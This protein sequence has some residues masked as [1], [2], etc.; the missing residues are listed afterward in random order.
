MQLYITMR[1][2]MPFEKDIG[3]FIL[4][5]ACTEST[6]LSAPFCQGRRSCEFG[7]SLAPTG[8]R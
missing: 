4:R 3:T 6:N 2:L 1:F 8:K 7:G 5:A